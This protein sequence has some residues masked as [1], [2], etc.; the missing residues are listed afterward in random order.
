[1]PRPKA[2]HHGKSCIPCCQGTTQAGVSRSFLKE[3]LPLQSLHWVEESGVKLS[4]GKGEEVL[5]AC[6]SASHY[7]NVLKYAINWFLLS[8]VRFSHGGN[9]WV[10]FLALFQ[11]RSF[12][13][14]FFVLSYGDG[15]SERA[16]GGV[17]C[18]WPRLPH[19]RTECSVGQTV[20]FVLLKCPELQHMCAEGWQ[21]WCGIHGRPVSCGAV[22]GGQEC[23]KA[24]QRTLG[25]NLWPPDQVPWISGWDQGLP[26]Q[27]MFLVIFFRKWGGYKTELMAINRFELT[28]T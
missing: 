13:S 26:Q 23:L 24:P 28:R 21:G 22:V 15:G 9:W 3:L 12:S 4:L 6:L 11:P 8:W 19:P 10:I 16:A 1:M 2:L 18:P 14:C 20:I 27:I 17:L 5:F 25:T 7:L